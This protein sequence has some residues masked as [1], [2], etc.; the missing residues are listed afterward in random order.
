M[1]YRENLLRRAQNTAILYTS[2]P[3]IDSTELKSIHQ[4]T[5]LWTE[6]EV[7]L[8]D[9]ALNILYS[10]NLNYL[11]PKELSDNYARSFY[12]YFSV[13]EKD[14]VCSRIKLNNRTYFSFVLA[15][16]MR[17]SEN[18]RNLRKIIFWSIILSIILAAIFSYLVSRNAIRPI[19]ELIEKANK[20]NSFSMGEKIFDIN[21]NDE[22]G[23]LA[24]SFNDMLSKLE[25]VFK[26]QDEFVSNASHEL[27]TPLT[28]MISETDYVLS[29]ERTKEEYEEHIRKIKQDLTHLNFLSNSLLELTQL[30]GDIMDRKKVRADEIIHKATYDIKLKY[31]DRKIV[32]K[33][34]YSED[35]NDFIIYGNAGLLE[36]AFRNI[37]DN[38]C[39]FSNEEILIEVLATFSD[40]KVF[41]T[42]KGIGI[43][44]GEIKNLFKPF[45]RASNVKYYS[46]HG[47]GLSLVSKI[48]NLH[49]ASI[50]MVVPEGGGTRVE[51]IFKK[52][53]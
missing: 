22:I 20:I 24:S 30:N 15:Y 19:S 53:I 1:K 14:G 10:N 12:K 3:E 27:R 46:G 25:D 40:L 2:V 29:R 34:R 26:S 11:D 7:A 33:I 21:S 48:I 50:N 4:S 5:F 42:D 13:N 38:A 51:I 43:P 47:V 52:T 6:E 35:Q 9:S 31:T 32:S 41:I 37:I 17:R 16:D 36:L 18:L 23:K 44:P 45:S 39:K 28:I 8:T 49:N